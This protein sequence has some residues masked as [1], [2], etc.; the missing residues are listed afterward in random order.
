MIIVIIMLP[1]VIGLAWELLHK[2]DDVIFSQHFIFTYRSAKD[3]FIQ[4]FIDITTLPYEVFLNVHAIGL[5]L[6]RMLISRK[7]LLQWNP[8]HIQQKQRGVLQ[9]YLKMWTAPV[10]AAAIFLYLSIYLPVI[11]TFAY[12]LLALWSLSPALMWLV[13]RR[14]ENQQASLSVIQTVYLRKLARKTWA[15]FETFVTEEDNW[16]PPDNYQE[17]PV[18]RVAHRTSP[19]NIGMALLSNVTAHDFGYITTGQLIER[20][21]NTI[22][23]MQRMEK[24]RGHLYNWYDTKSLVP[25]APKYISTV[26][27]GN[28]AGHLIT[29][30]QALLSLADIKI[31]SP[32]F[33]DGFIDVLGIIAEK[34]ISNVAA[35]SF[36]KFSKELNEHY[37]TVINNL[38]DT[39]KIF[40]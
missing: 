27:S 3:R 12:P 35:A 38:A 26:D 22:G 37:P 16:L 5:T 39:K 20:T 28:L 15:F 21:T 40:R 11:L 34:T 25:L 9:F 6:W 18:E 31:A 24:Y 30:K 4:L 13:S 23:T 32:A 17:H 19:T 36:K 10:F 7:K 29:L 33:F 14:G 1:A 8:S 2:P